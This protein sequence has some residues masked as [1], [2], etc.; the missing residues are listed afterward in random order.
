MKELKKFVGRVSSGFSLISQI[1]LAGVMVL[2]IGNIILRRFGL[3]IP[4]TVEMVE[5]G[6]TLILGSSIAYC[7][8]SGGHIFVD[9]LFQKLS[10]RNKSLI[11][12]ITN[13]IMLLLNSIL[14]WQIFV[15]GMRMTERGFVTGH[16]G[17]PIA[18]VVYV[19]GI[20]FVLMGLVNLTH[21]L[22]SGKI[23]IEGAKK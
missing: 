1:A 23:L 4:G 11:D 10:K 9:V 19:M 16:L 22:N 5:L 7:L 2:I 3:A 21:L 14:S 12:L 6:G 17:I 18:P 13:F 20:G 15:Y 8:H